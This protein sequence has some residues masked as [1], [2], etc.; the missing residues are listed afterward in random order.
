MP[1]LDA[2]FKAYDV[3]G[4]VPDQLDA[5]VARAVGGAFARFSGAPEI[6]VGRDMRSS[7]P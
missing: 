2:I 1:R 5:S 7:G 6:V 3:R 4:T